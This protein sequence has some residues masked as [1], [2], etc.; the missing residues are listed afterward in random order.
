MLDAR[1]C[2]EIYEFCQ[3]QYKKLEKKTGHYSPKHD[4]V[5]MELAAKEFQMS[6]ATIN[7]AFDL[8]AQTL[9]K[10]N[11]IKSEK[12]IRNKLIHGNF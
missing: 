3:S 4:K 1:K 6:E 2:L 8:A 12:I 7:N 9:S 11:R 5:V 10:N